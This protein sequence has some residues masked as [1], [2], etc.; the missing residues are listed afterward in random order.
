MAN[1]G[2]IEF[3]AHTQHHVNLL[4]LDYKTDYDEMIQ[5]NLD[6][7]ALVGKCQSFAYTFGRFNEKQKKISKEI[8]FKN[9]V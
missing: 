7:E 4:K 3:G 5:S 2:L 1:S 6:F 9:E 8:G